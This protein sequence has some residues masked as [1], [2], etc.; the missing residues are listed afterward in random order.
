MDLNDKAFNSFSNNLLNQILLHESYIIDKLVI[1]LKV[2]VR[3]GIN[4]N[5]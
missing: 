2:M 5:I 4:I 3:I 1:V